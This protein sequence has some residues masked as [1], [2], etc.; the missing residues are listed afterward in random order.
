MAKSAADRGVAPQASRP[1]K[2]VHGEQYEHP[3]YLNAEALDGGSELD[4]P[5]ENR[6]GEI[7]LIIKREKFGGVK[8]PRRQQIEWKH[9]TTE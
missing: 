7:G 3:E 4:S 2:L 8:D 5:R 6:R 1:E 9:L